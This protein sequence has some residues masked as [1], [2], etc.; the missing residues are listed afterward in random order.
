MYAVEMLNITKRFG[1]NLIANNNVSLR[2]NNS[3][4]HAIVGENGAGKTTL[5]KIL[6]G[7]L[8][9]SS[10]KIFINGTQTKIKNPAHAISLGIG[11]VHQHFMLVHGLTVIENILLGNEKCP[12]FGKVELNK[13][14]AEIEKLCGEFNFYIP[15]HPKIEELTVGLQQKAEIIKLLYRNA[16]IL[17][18]DEPTA[19]LTPQEI[20]DLFNSLKLLIRKNKTIIL[21]THKLNEVIEISD[22]V[23]VMRNGKLIVTKS[24][25]DTSQK[26]LSRYMIGEDNTAGYKYSKE[27]KIQKETILIAE[28]VIIEDEKKVQKVKGVSFTLRSGEITGIAGVEG[29]GQTELADAVCGLHKVKQGRIIFYGKDQQLISHIPSDRLKNGIVKEFNLYENILLSRQNEERY[30]KNGI[31]NYKTIK[32]DTEKLVE[33]YDIKTSTLKQSISE[34]SGGNQQKLVAARELTK[35][36]RLI[37]IN[38]PTRGLDIKASEFVHNCIFEERSKGKAILLVSSDLSEL[39]KLCDTIMVMYNGRIVKT[40]TASETTENEIGK[41]MTGGNTIG[42]LRPEI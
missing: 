20:T 41:Y 25:A 37:V 34:L 39:L 11:M 40:L 26:E 6:Y 30:F 27:T 10:G 7:M 24:T 1:E 33:K 14:K 29:N 36:S 18:L 42:D 16:D 17:I 28:N 3:E 2:V 31:L 5:M 38:H 32:D 13:A 35:N 21:I 22:R 9:P 15:L 23:S 19:V 12:A 4:I 8:R